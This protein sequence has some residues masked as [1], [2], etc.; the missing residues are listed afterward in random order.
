MSTQD[1]ND[2]SPQINRRS[3][4]TTAA[5]ASAALAFARPAKLFGAT[6]APSDVL[7]VALVGIGAQ[8]RVLLDDTLKIPGVR[9]VAI[10]DIW[11]YNRQYAEKYLKK[12]GHTVK[13]YRDYEDMLA[14][15]KDIQ[16]V[17]VATP[18]F[19][20]API[21]IAAMKAGKDVYCEKMMSNT[22]E[23]AKS[24]VRSMKETGRLLQIGHQ[25]RSNPRYLVAK[26]RLLGEAN[27]LGKIT[28]ANGQWNRAVSEDLGWPNRA[29]IPKATLAKYG[30]DD[31]HQFRNWRWFKKFGG[32]PLSDLGAHQI[33]IFNWFF[34]GPPVSV[35]ADGGNDHY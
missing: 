23:G 21:S 30:Y 15:E 18:D 34:G 3:F 27:L 25:R 29:A 31:M 11:D 6:V 26:N 7:N 8:G 24:M 9:F 12:F 10:C 14:Q 17:I 20:H 22:I 2:S 33:D 19:L 5:T 28:T 16:A 4:I 13:S 35:S 32:G 1:K